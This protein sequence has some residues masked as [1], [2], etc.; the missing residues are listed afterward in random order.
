M[1]MDVEIVEPSTSVAVD[2]PPGGS[3][4]IEKI[5][6]GFVATVQ[7]WGTSSGITEDQHVAHEQNLSV[8][9]RQRKLHAQL[10]REGGERVRRAGHH[11]VRERDLSS[12]G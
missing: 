10:V 7:T 5:S 4:M 3:R 8:V 1:A 2:A 12:S 6:V 9:V 11:G